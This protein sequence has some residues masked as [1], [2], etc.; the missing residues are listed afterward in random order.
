MTN[1][2]EDPCPVCGYAHVNQPCIEMTLPEVNDVV[3]TA[4]VILGKSSGDIRNRQGADKVAAAE[5]ADS[6]TRPKAS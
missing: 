4:R 5:V 1:Q 2:L 6:S 3:N